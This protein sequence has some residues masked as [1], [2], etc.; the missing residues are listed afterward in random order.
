MA[1]HPVLLNSISEKAFQQQLNE[2]ATLLGYLCFHT[3][4]SRRSIGGGFPDLV[5]VRPATSKHTSRVI[6]A[7]LKTQKG[8]V[9]KAQQEWLQALS[10]RE[11]IEVYIWRPADIDTIIEILQ[12][13]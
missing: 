3:Y 9:S 6:F 7:E 2:M 11:G 10:T 1:V 5:L 13:E 4:D 8:R 12:R